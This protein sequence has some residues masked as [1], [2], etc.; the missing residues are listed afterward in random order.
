MSPS[1][2]SAS[3]TTPGRLPGTSSYAQRG[4]LLRFM[5]PL[6]VIML[7]TWVFSIV[8]LFGWSQ[9]LRY[10]AVDRDVLRALM[11]DDGPLADLLLRYVHEL[12][13]GVAV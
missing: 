5:A 8:L 9:P 2:D 10:I 7:F 12:L 11:F 3:I 4:S 1:A 13:S 6:D